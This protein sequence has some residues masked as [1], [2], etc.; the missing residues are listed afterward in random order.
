MRGKSRE[1][2]PPAPPPSLIEKAGKK[3]HETLH[4][5]TRLLIVSKTKKK[6]IKGS[7]TAVHIVRKGVATRRKKGKSSHPK[8]KKKGR[9]AKRGEKRNGVERRKI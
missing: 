8:Q 2:K 4:T 6:H 7:D 3:I 9:R 1:T 5:A